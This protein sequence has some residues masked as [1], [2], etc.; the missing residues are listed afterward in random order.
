VHASGKIT[1]I[2]G[3]GKECK[4]STASCG[5]GGKATHAELARPHGAAITKHGVYIADRNDNR[6]RFVDIDLP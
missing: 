1:T 3:S 2:A 4:P 5:D 6:I